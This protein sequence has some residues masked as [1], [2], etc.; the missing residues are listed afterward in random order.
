MKPRFVALLLLAFTLLLV[1]MIPAVGA[2]PATTEPPAQLARPTDAPARQRS[3][4]PAPDP[5]Q[6]QVDRSVDQR[7]LERDPEYARQ[8]ER[9]MSLDTATATPPAAPETPAL[10]QQ[11]GPPSGYPDPEPEPGVT[12]IRASVDPMGEDANNSSYDP[13]IT[14]DGR[15]VAFGSYADDLL[16]GDWNEMADIFVRDTQT[17]TTERVSISTGGDEANEG[18]YAPSISAD[19]RYVVF[20]SYAD[21]L[22]AGDTNW[23]SDIFLHDRQT[24]ETTLISR[25]TD[26]TQ[27]NSDSY[28]PAISGNGQFVTYSSYADNLVNADSNY[29]SDIFVYE[30]ATE[31]TTRVSQSS[32]ATQGTSD[33]FHPAISQSGQFVTFDSY[34]NNL[35]NTDSNGWYPDI[36][37]Y[38]QDNHETKLISHHNNGTQGNYSSTEPAIS[39][40]GKVIAF[41][42]YADNLVDDDT[43]NQGDVFI[44][45]V[46]ASTTTLISHHSDGTQGTNV[47]YRAAISDDGLF[48]AFIS[49]ATNLIDS[50]TNGNQ[51]VFLYDIQNNLTTLASKSVTGEQGSN[52][53]DYPALNSNGTAIAF[54]SSA[55]NLVPFDQNGYTQDVFVRFTDQANLYTISG[56]VT[57]EYSNGLGWELVRDIS[58]AAVETDEDGYY[59]LVGLLPGEHGVWVDSYYNG[60]YVFSY[61]PVPVTVPPD[62]TNV[63]FVGYYPDTFFNVYEPIADAYVDQA[64]TSTNYGTKPYLRVKNASKD[65]ETYLKFD[66]NDLPSCAEVDSS[67]LGLYA[68]DP[69]PDGGKVFFPSSNDWTETGITWNN[70]PGHDPFWWGSFGPVTNPDYYW[71]DIPPV[72]IGVSH[73]VVWNDS[74]D[75]VQYDSREGANPPRLEVDWYQLPDRRPDAQYGMN[76]DDGLA[77]LTVQFTDQSAGCPDTWAWDFGDGGTSTERNPTHTFTTPGFYEVVLTITNSEGVDKKMQQIEVI[78]PPDQV[79]MSLSKKLTVGGLTIEPADIV[80]YDKSANTWQMVYD[81]SEHDTMANISSFAWDGDD[82]L[83][84]FSGSQTI[85]GL[86]KATQYDVVRFTPNTPLVFPLGPGLFDWELQGAPNGLTKGSE[87]IDALGFDYGDIPLSTIGKTDLTPYSELLANK[88]DIFEWR[89]GW[90]NTLDLDGSQIPGMAGR[91]INGLWFDDKTHDY[92]VIITG[93]FNLGGVAGND[94]SIVRLTWANGQWVPSLH[95]WLAPGAPAFKGKIDAIELGR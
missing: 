88:E 7:R 31:T 87:K 62:A 24:G 49:W 16:V 77:P 55:Y 67:R 57:D 41:L 90:G 59:F 83:I 64:K 3:A 51:D 39:G 63:D 78:K 50:D 21:N 75:Q 25:H 89:G 22:V 52:F 9:E 5:S 76:T 72:T 29:S 15:Y 92:Y 65:L 12:V 80:L 93:K 32:D 40:D 1:G 45:D 74:S 30:V 70:A 8:M 81:G 44:Y 84:V 73:F 56:Q 38:D 2:Q 27:G 19:G 13:D 46:N 20:Y 48:V 86:G 61:T 10:P 36:F 85:A 26:G 11:A 60:Y 66:I 17:N 82:L 6:A 54:N 34:A 91:N 23:S 58:G 18:S 69:G 68:T 79:F 71:T 37:L 47:S 95:N 35:V 43:N 53:S 94:A 14:S 33:S 4:A 42:S 28:D